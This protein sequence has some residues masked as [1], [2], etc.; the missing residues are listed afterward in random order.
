MLRDNLY[1]SD[2]FLCLADFESYSECQQKV[3]AAFRQKS[4]WAKMAILNTARIGKILKRPHHC[5][6]RARHL[7]DRADR[8]LTRRARED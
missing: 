2:P 5:G 8:Y 7:E 6:I 1:Y 3:E 4:R